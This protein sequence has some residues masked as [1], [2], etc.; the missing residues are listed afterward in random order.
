[1]ALPGSRDREGVVKI[2]A[3][4]KIARRSVDGRGFMLTS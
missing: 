4:G 3:I 1:M 2:D